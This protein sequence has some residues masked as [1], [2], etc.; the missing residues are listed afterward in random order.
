VSWLS[1]KCGSL[2]VSQ[3][4]GPPRPVTEIALR[5]IVPS[6]CV[7]TSTG[8]LPYLHHNIYQS[9]FYRTPLTRLTS[10]SQE[11]WCDCFVCVMQWYRRIETHASAIGPDILFAPIRDG[12]RFKIPMWASVTKFVLCLF[13]P[14]NSL[15]QCWLHRTCL[16]PAK[17]F[18]SV[19]YTYTAIAS[20]EF[21]YWIPG[22][23]YVSMWEY[24]EFISLVTWPSQSIFRTFR[25]G[26]RDW[27]SVCMPAI[28]RVNM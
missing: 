24:A 2:V 14:H 6:F 10:F 26:Q 13:V 21:W 8:T 12:D 5:C 1:R 7:S 11:T 18:I 20:T 16:S 23:F 27:G 28:C 22:S 3:P 4:Y 19:A 9:P 17:R 15:S 25:V